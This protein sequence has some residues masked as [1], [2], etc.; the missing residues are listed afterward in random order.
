[1]IALVHMYILP[2][3]GMLYLNIWFHTL[4]H[5]EVNYTAVCMSQEVNWYNGGGAR[6]RYAFHRTINYTHTSEAYHWSTT[7]IFASFSTSGT[8][9]LTWYH[10]IRYNG[11]HRIK[12]G[13]GD[14]PPVWDVDFLIISTLIPNQMLLYFIS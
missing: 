14:Q 7:T 3:R 2:L 10:L 1:M 11:I 12:K 5:S 9:V 13:W 6:H 4:F 8:G